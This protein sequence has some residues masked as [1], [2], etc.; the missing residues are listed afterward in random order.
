MCVC[1]CVWLARIDLT[2]LPFIRVIHPSFLSRVYGASNEETIAFTVR[3]C[4]RYICTYTS[5]F[6][7]AIVQ[8]NY[9]EIVGIWRI[10]EKVRN[11]RIVESKLGRIERSWACTLWNRECPSVGVF[12][13]ELR[14]M[15]RY[16]SRCFWKE[17]SARRLGTCS[18][19]KIR[20]SGYLKVRA[21]LAAHVTIF[22]VDRNDL[23]NQ[24]K[25]F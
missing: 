4:T 17:N 20:E 3:F 9:L 21:Y 24:F 11:E 16:V 13:G 23:T 18:F 25:L 8:S 15:A 12:V 2:K 19:I 22:S 1:V 14:V 6:R 10:F 5:D 7:S